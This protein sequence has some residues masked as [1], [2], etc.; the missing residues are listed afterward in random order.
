MESKP[1]TKTHLVEEIGQG[2]KTK[3]SFIFNAF[4]FEKMDPELHVRVCKAPIPTLTTSPAVSSELVEVHEHFVLVLGNA[5]VLFQVP[6]LTEDEGFIVMI[7]CSTNFNTPWL[8][9]YNTIIIIMYYVFW[10]QLTSILSA[11]PCVVCWRQCARWQLQPEIHRSV[12]D[13]P[14]RQDPQN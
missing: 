8:H 5:A 14:W 13:H 9:N 3:L 2:A 7:R 11:M 4:S 6:V 1:V 12:G 10:K